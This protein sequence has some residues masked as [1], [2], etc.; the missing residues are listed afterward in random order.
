[1]VTGVGESLSKS[2]GR[3]GYELRRRI[4]E[5]YIFSWLDAVEDAACLSL[6]VDAGIVAPAVGGEYQGRDKVQ[7]TVARRPFRIVRTVGLA[8]PCKVPHPVAT[9]V[10]H[11]LLAPSPQ[12][13]EDILLSKLYGNH[14][15]IGHSFRAGIIVLY[16]ADIS[17]RVADLKIDFVR[18]SENIVEHLLQL[19]I[20][21]RRLVAHIHK[22][23][24]VFSRCESTFRPRSHLCRH[25]HST[26]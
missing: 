12:A 16:V 20:H 11:I 15:A 5:K 25:I 1:M 9:L 19:G 26:H 14:H 24:T 3:K 2:V 18:P 21:L 6:V 10:L 23:V 13:V 22:Y 17:H 8:A 7:F 4:D